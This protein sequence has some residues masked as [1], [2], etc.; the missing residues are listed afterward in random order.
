MQQ[1]QQLIKVLE[2][3]ETMTDGF[4]DGSTLHHCRL[5]KEVGEPGKPGG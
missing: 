4:V 2:A 5:T 1:V 3:D